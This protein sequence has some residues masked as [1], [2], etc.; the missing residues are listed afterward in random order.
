MTNKVFGW[1]GIIA[2]GIVVIGSLVLLYQYIFNRSQEVTLPSQNGRE[3]TMHTVL[4]RDAI[5]SIDDPQFYSAEA[6]DAEYRDSELIIG[7]AI[8]GDARAY[9]V[10]LLSSHE[11]VN[12]TAGGV[13]IAV[14]W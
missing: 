13:P 3:V 10:P 2:I 11:I 8:N 4:G 1:L 5:P 12:D 14:T 7:V 6:A 9:S